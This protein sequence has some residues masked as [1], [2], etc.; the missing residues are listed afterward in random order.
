MAIKA[1]HNTTGLFQTSSGKAFIGHF[2]YAGSSAPQAGMIPA[3]IAY[4]LLAEKNIVIFGARERKGGG[5]LSFGWL[6]V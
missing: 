6:H 5:S 1:S 3:L 4:N 2:V